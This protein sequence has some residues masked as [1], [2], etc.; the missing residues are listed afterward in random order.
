M[1]AINEVSDEVLRNKINYDLCFYGIYGILPDDASDMSA[2]F[3]KSVEV[4]IQG[5]HDYKKEQVEKGIKGGRPSKV[6]DEELKEA[7]LNFY[8]GHGKLPSNSELGAIVGLS[9]GAIRQ[10][11]P[12]KEKEGILIEFLQ[13][14]EEE[15]KIY[16][17]KGF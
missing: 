11:K 5:S 1:E 15:V 3:I 4:L 16:D 7:M 12:W 10:R 8:R 2:L 6:S 14:N 17:T 9:G 13:E